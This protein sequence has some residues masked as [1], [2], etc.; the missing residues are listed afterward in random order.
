MGAVLE[1]GKLTL[2]DDVDEAIAR[3]EANMAVPA[4][5]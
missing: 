4:K 1:N 2:Y 3:H 5:G